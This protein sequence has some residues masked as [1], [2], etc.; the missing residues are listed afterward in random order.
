MDELYQEYERLMCEG[1]ASE[2]ML[3]A[4]LHELANKPIYIY[5]ALG[6]T[7]TLLMLRLNEL[8]ISIKGGFDR[9]SSSTVTNGLHF[10]VK[11]SEQVSELSEE[12]VLVLAAGSA[13]LFR[14]MQFEV[15][16][17]SAGIGPKII[18]GRKLTYVLQNLHCANLAREEKHE[19][20]MTCIGYHTKPFKC[21][22]FM[23]LTERLASK[24][25]PQ[26]I[27]TD[28]S[29]FNSVGYLIGEWCN[30][31]CAQCCEAVPYLDSKEM[32]SIDEIVADLKKLTASIT[33]LHRL[34]IVGGEPFAHRN[35]AA[36]IKEIRKLPGIGYIAV[37]TNGTIMPSDEL[38]AALASERVIVTNSDYS[39]SL[40]DAQK[41][42][43]KDTIEKL[44]RHGVQVVQIADRYWFD[45]I[46]F[47]RNT[48]ND[49][50]LEK[51]YRDCFLESCRR[52]Y[53]GTLF[54]CAVQ[55][56]GVKLGRIPK[57]N[58]VELHT[59]CAE[60]IRRQLDVFESERFI[61][62][63]RYCALPIGA[64]EVQAALQLK[65]GKIRTR[66]KQL[67]ASTV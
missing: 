44:K 60:E 6:R 48:V 36:I 27:K 29:T 64:K 11:P 42:K 56:N 25:I 19:N 15:N 62:S 5:G 41:K 46:Q 61:E 47:Q 65:D 17:F 53:R 51:N 57:T 39:Q 22:Y 58:V 3:D 24:E 14:S 43:I 33:F 21:E 8:A 67:D 52:L 13:E 28:G 31:K 1:R 10:A 20:L 30:L 49:Q 59:A 63:C 45:L 16:K 26:D 40:N 38:C 32:V 34:D 12:D 54:H 18:D 37:F 7:A 66:Q 50:E 2:H 23:R 4:V 55:A 9:R 35:I